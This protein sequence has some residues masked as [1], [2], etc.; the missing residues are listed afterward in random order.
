MVDQ[1]I[2]QISLFSRLPD[3]EIQHLARTLRILDLPPGVVLCRE[4][5]RGDRFYIVIAGELDIL[6][7]LGDEERYLGARG[8]GNFV[9]EMSLFNPESLRT[10]S[11]RTRTDVRLLEMTHLEFDALLHRQPSIAYE[12]MRELSLRLRDTDDAVIRDLQEKNQQLAKAYA[13]LKAAQ[14]QLIEKERLE[15]ELQ[16]ARQ[17]QESILPAELP[18]LPDFDFGARMAPARAVGGDFFDLFILDEHRVGVAIADVSDKGV[19]AAIFMALTRSLLRAEAHEA[20]PPAQVLQHVNQHLLEMNQAGMFVTVLYGV[21]DRRDRTFA[22][23]RAGHENPL[24]FEKDGRLILPERQVGQPL[25]ILPEPKLDEQ[26][27]VLPPDGMLFLYTDGVPDALNMQ[28]EPFGRDRLCDVVRA[29]L[30]APAQAVCDGVLGVICAYQDIAP[31][32][33]DITLM[34]LSNCWSAA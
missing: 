33:D 27:L 21:L 1:L 12:G 5:E 20:D 4:G 30:C 10:A 2:R 28:A 32:T 7:A 16:L 17:I 9:G 6:K 29:N 25:G 18:R 19:P 26:I 11:V 31:S 8:P 23:A 15:R 3:S 34:A 14:A 24:L 22:Y 13:E